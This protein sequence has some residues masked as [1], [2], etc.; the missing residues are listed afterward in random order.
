MSEKMNCPFCGCAIEPGIPSCPSCGSVFEEPKLPNIK[1][2]EFGWFFALHIITK[3]W[4]GIIW[5]L[6][7]AKA[8]NK[9]AVNPKD[10][11]KINWLIF[12][13]LVFVILYLSLGISVSPW[14]VTITAFFV[15]YFIYVALA[16]R[17]LRIIQK[18]T[19]K[20]Y[21]TVIEINP[22]YIALF[23]IFYLAHFIDTYTNRVQQTHEHFNMKWQYLIMLIII[24]SVAPIALFMF[25]PPLYAFLLFFKSLINI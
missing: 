9:L 2:Q 20:T 3:G 22:Y 15:L 5:F 13:L 8:I 19:L 24:F 6:M 17:T 14:L 4:F 10:N 7:N 1:C 23:N 12:L 11:L 21:N 18:Y 16:H 25:N